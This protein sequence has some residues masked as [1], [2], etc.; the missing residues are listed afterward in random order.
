M[1]KI[2]TLKSTVYLLAVFMFL[3]VTAPTVA[4]VQVSPL[5][6]ESII[7]TG[8]NTLSPVIVTNTDTK[9]TIRIK[10]EVLGF[11]QNDAGISIPLTEDQSQNTAVPFIS[12]NPAEFELKPGESGK[13]NLNASIPSGSEGGKYATIVIGQVPE[14]G[15]SILGNVAVIVMLTIGE[16]TL[17]KSLQITG[18]TIERLE[19]D[20]PI[21][22]ITTINNSG[23][24]HVRPGGQISITKDEK[25]IENLNVEP[26][27]I[28]PGY[29]R[30][31]VTKWDPPQNA[32][33][34]YSF[35]MNL[36]MDGVEISSKGSFI[37]NDKGELTDIEGGTGIPVVQTTQADKKNISVTGQSMDWR[38]I[39]EII[40]GVI[41][42]GLFV[43]LF[44]TRKRA[45]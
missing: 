11:G 19:P 5:S 32:G 2:I 16:S 45:G 29:D 31:F 7:S 43:Y 37:I 24:I 30:Q 9:E 26:H 42:T 25:K 28:I 10:A 23:N 1:L 20:G 38:L 39:I 12:L 27:L 6:I 21:T 4:A 18:V 14:A 41:V 13:I 8:N 33:G 22:F 3:N 17:V 36:E 40:V 15:V 34:N 35:Q 44:K